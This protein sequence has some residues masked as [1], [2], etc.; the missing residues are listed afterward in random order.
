MEYYVGLDVSVKHKAIC[1][2]DRDGEVVREAALYTD[3]ETLAAF[4]HGT[5]C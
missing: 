1:V 5:G 4:L 3:P 2:V